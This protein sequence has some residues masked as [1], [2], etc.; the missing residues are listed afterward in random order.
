MITIQTKVQDSTAI[1]FLNHYSKSFSFL[2][3]KLFVDLFIREK[4]INDLKSE[5]Q[6]EYGILA[7]QFNSISTQT[8]AKWNARKEQYTRTIKD[9][10]SKVRDVD[11]F[12]K[13]EEKKIA[14][15]QKKLGK[16]EE[17]K[18]KCC[19]RLKKRKM[20][21]S[22]KKLDANKLIEDIKKSE[23]LIESKKIRRNVLLKKLEKNKSDLQKKRVCFGG[24]KLFNLQ[25]NLEES[26]YESH[27]EWKEIWQNRRDG[28]CFFVGSKEETKGNQ[29]VQWCKE[30]KSLQIRVAPFLRD[31]FGKYIECPLNFSEEHLQLLNEAVGR[32]TAISYRF[33]KVVETTR[34]G[35]LKKLL[36]KAGEFLG[37]KSNFYCYVTF[38][39]LC[40]EPVV[41]S[42]E[43]GVV[44]L[45]INADHL[46]LVETDSSGNPIRNFSVPYFVPESSSDQNKAIL[47]DCVATVLDFCLQAKKP[48]VVEELDLNKKK[49]NLR[50]KG[51]GAFYNR[52]LSQF[53][54]GRIQQMLSSRANKTG[55]KI[56]PINPAFTSV[57]GAYKYRGYTSLT[58][59]HCAALVI[60]RRGQGFREGS[61]IFRGM[62]P[63]ERMDGL[64]LGPALP[65]LSKRK[66]RHIW[67]YWRA[68]TRKIRATL[69][70]SIKDGAMNDRAIYLNHLLF[71]P[72]RPSGLVPIIE[73]FR[74]KGKHEGKW[75]QNFCHHLESWTCG[76]LQSREPAPSLS[77]FE[78]GCHE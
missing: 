69:Q 9:L 23:N 16:I 24:E 4:P 38:E 61:K 53:Q 55:V 12:I 50:E 1:D 15:L 77:L 63:P 71:N 47:G 72:G 7:R 52:M 30:S 66:A 10:Q 18:E 13:G 68:H 29:N 20:P 21:V 25:F 17:Y 45:D 37:F 46:A 5:Y 22:L 8:R 57:I 48:L 49:T 75:W 78:A 54:F 65:F 76:E 56:I 36:N 59:H 33:T 6:R 67:S 35:N 51:K 62:H 41:V 28:S 43:R 42:K 19:S 2:V 31:L 64:D 58:S 40:Q 11:K 3:R 39:P 44:G 27:A 14:Q 32:E 70:A 73:V 74:E 34:T 26:P 60:A